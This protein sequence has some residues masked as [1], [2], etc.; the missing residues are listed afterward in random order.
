MAG[1]GFVIRKLVE[2][3]DL[4]GAAMGYLYAA[5]ISTGP[6]LFTIICL[7]LIVVFGNSFLALHELAAFRIII[8]Y[9][10]CFSLVLSAPIYM[11]ATRCLADMIYA[12]DVSPAPGLMLGSLILLWLLCLP[13]AGVFYGIYAQ[14]DNIVRFS[15]VVNFLLISAIWLTSIFI[16]ALRDYA[17]IARLFGLGMS[18]ALGAALWLAESYSVSGMLTGFNTGLAL[19]LFGLLARILAEYPHHLIKPFSFLAYFRSHWEIAISSLLY[20]MAI[21]TDKWI[22]WFAPE[23]QV[24]ESGLISFPHYDGAMFLAYLSMVPAIALFTVHVETRFFEQYLRFYQ[25]IKQHAA[26]QRIEHSRRGLWQVLLDSGQSLLIWQVVVTVLLIVSAPMLLEILKAS[27]LQTGIFRFGVLGALF[28]TMTLFLIII[29][30]YFD[31]RLKILVISAI[32]LSAN[33]G[34]SMLS[35]QWGFAWYGWGYA[36]ASIVTFALSY[37]ITIRHID[38]LSYETFIMRNEHREF[39]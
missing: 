33:T 22:M 6:W 25:D 27:T 29:L 9:N 12:R 31:A 21:W 30:S 19:I 35:L 23:R 38:N 24:Q 26:Y 15:A 20:S 4:S 34:L 18:L 10:F 1:I 39:L 17:S 5:L 7:G 3:D 8:I 2:R 28:H 16:S 14:L 32:F 11:I 36:A 37:L 13:V